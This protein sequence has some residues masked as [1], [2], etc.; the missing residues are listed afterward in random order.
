M[1]FT[2]RVICIP[3]LANGNVPK[4]AHEIAIPVAF[5]VDPDAAQQPAIAGDNVAIHYVMLHLFCW[6]QDSLL[7][8]QAIAANA[9]Q[10]ALH[11]D[12]T[13][14]QWQTTLLPYLH[15]ACSATLANLPEHDWPFWEQFAQRWQLRHFAA[16]LH[17]AQRGRQVS[18]EMKQLSPTPAM[19]CLPPPP[20]SPLYAR[21]L[22]AR[23][24]TP[25]PTWLAHGA[26][27]SSGA[28]AQQ[29]E[30]D[31]M[32]TKLPRQAIVAWLVDAAKARA[33]T[34]PRR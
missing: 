1:Q 25:Q 16:D 24:P 6:Q 20:L 23:L 29:D 31:P 27:K 22:A 28:S 12:I 14:T 5:R 11:M 8:A 32:P 26:G 21:S 9:Q 17:I 10:R 33:L 18:A 3:A 34:R 7:A 4:S 30:Q 15:H 13:Y 19:A 2:T